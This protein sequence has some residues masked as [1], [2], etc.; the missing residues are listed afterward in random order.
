MAAQAGKLASMLMAG[1]SCATV[2]RL[3]SRDLPDFKRMDTTACP[4]T[5]G[6]SCWGL[7]IQKLGESQR[8]FFGD[9]SRCHSYH[10]KA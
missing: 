1:V 3:S 10:D 8:G 9:L 6:R 5:V 2:R 4:P 7:Y